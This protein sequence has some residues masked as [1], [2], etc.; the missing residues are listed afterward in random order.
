MYVVVTWTAQDNPTVEAL[1]LRALSETQGGSK[2]SKK[3]LVF[4]H[5]W[6]ILPHCVLANFPGGAGGLPGLLS[7]RLD[8][9]RAEP[10]APV[11]DYLVTY[12]QQGNA[13]FTSLPGPAK[14]KLHNT[15]TR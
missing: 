2:K 15:V 3:K 14:T 13:A 10:G 12:C 5:A 11:F 4:S 1:V 8:Q 7:D 6:V 9:L